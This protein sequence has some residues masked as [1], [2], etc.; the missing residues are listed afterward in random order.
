[1]SGEN[2]ATKKEKRR[3]TRIGQTFIKLMIY[4][5]KTNILMSSVQARQEDETKSRMEQGKLRMSRPDID[6]SSEV[7]CSLWI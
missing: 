2:A 4:R 5:Y 1:M 7:N 3:G 6:C